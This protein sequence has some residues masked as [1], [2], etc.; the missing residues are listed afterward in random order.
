MAHDRAEAW[1][2]QLT[3]LPT[4]PGHEGEVIRW[5][6][7]WAKRRPDLELSADRAGNLFITQRLPLRARPLWI[8][9]HLDHPAFVV[10]DVGGSSVEWEFRGG[11]RPAYFDD[12]LIEFHR[13][14]KPQGKARIVERSSDARTGVA[15]LV[16]GSATPST[17]DIGR[18]WFREDALGVRRGRLRAHAC[19][20]LAGV[21]AA[22]SVLDELRSG[23]EHGHIGV[24]LT[25]AE[26]VG[27]VGAI[28]AAKGSRLSPSSRLICLEM[29]RSF[30]DAPIGGGPVVRVGDASSVFSPQLTNALTTAAGAWSSDHGRPHQRKLMAGGS[31]EATAFA[32]YGFE[33]ACLCLPLGNYHNMGRLDEVEKGRT[34]ARVGPEEIA[35]RDWHGLVDFLVDRVGALE[36]VQP[37][38]RERLDELFEAG[39]PILD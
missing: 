18:W 39:R 1:L 3:A 20:D 11:V 12:A 27:F 23:A 4:A 16:R 24:L 32:A 38:L 25:R 13:G 29:S 26:E 37:G 14:A 30:S 10:T 6:R 28:A 2:R 17:G 33:A 22:L 21:A 35:L 8:T 31:C 9:A 5:V 19:D 34:P 36:H 15:R 7:S